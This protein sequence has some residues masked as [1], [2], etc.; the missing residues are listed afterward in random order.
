MSVNNVELAK[1]W[2]E[3]AENDLVSASH[4]IKLVDGPLDN[5]CFHAQQVVE[6]SLKGLLTIHQVEFTKTHN[7][8]LLLDLCLP[9]IPDLDDYREQFAEMTVYAVET[10]YPGD[11]FMPSQEEAKLAL[12]VGNEVLA[13]VKQHFTEKT[14][15]NK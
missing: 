5:V 12:G 7:L 15:E 8:L 3:K 2:I 1:L 6:K 11:F 4:L 9:F 10:R 13:I 14:G